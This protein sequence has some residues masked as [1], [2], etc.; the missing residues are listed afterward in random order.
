MRAARRVPTHHSGAAREWRA[1]FPFRLLLLLGCLPFLLLTSAVLVYREQQSD[2]IYAGVTALGVGLGRM[3]P[4]EASVAL[5]RQLVAESRRPLELRYDDDAFTTSLATMGLTIDDAQVD[6]WAGQAWQIGRDNDLRT[7]LRTQLALMRRGH[8][9]PVTLTFDRER[10]TAALARAAVEV[11]R[12]PVNA[13]L[14]V[15][16]AAGERFEVHTSPA[17]TGRRL[18]VPATLD[19]L[20]SALHNQL[21]TDVDLVLDEALPAIGDADI[22]PAVEALNNILGSPMEVKDGARTWTMTP[23][24]AFPML[25]VTGLEAGQPPVVARLNAAKL[26]PFVETITRQAT[27]PAV[28]AA[29]EVQNDRVA[30]RA[31]AAGKT[32]D[33]EATLKLFNER[34]GS[35]TRTVEIAFT[36]EQP[37][38][39]ESD[40]NAARDQVNALLDLP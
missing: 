29:F 35:T 38:V 2:K 10:A 40:L 1:G 13:G 34:V 32:A 22:A 33:L 9:L 15:E 5:K 30:V 6:A 4:Q 12:Q 18:N 19:R 14:A 23:V 25:E 16:Q 36:E 37:W 21:P 31:G 17:R 3:T 7:W 39:V 8:E 11:E 26:R 27:V 20:Q 28:N 24:Q